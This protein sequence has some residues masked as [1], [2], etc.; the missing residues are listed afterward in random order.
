MPFVDIGT[1]SPKISEKTEGLTANFV[2]D[3][4]EIKLQIDNG[5]GKVVFTKKGFPAK[6]FTSFANM[7]ASDDFAN[8][9]KWAKSQAELLGR[10]AAA[11]R[12]LLPFNARN[13]K[14]A[15]FEGV[16]QVNALFN[17]QPRP[18]DAAEVILIDGPAGIGKTKL[19]EQ[20]ALLR[21]E[22]YA[23]SPTSLILHVR[24]RGRVLS[25]LQDLMA[26][27]LQ[28]LRSNTTYDQIPILLKHGLIVVAIDGFDELGDPNG[29]ELAWSQV[30]DLISAARG[31]GVVL[32]SGRDT[33]LGRDRLFRDVQSLRQDRDVV[34][35]LT[36]EASTPDQAREWLKS[37]GWTDVHFKIPAV[38]S[39]L[40]DGSF[41]LR[42]VFLN[43]MAANLEPKRLREESDS[44][45]TPLLVK[46]ML[47]REAKLFGDAVEKIVSRDSLEDFLL[48]YLIEVAREMADGQSESLDETTLS[49]IVEIALGDG[50]PE[51]VV[52]LIRNRASVVAALKPDLRAGYKG[53]VHSHIQNYFLSLA[54]LE[55]VGKGEVPK[56]LKRNVLG[57]EMVAVF[58]DVAAKAAGT[59][60]SKAFL[61]HGLTMASLYGGVDRASRNVGALLMSTLALLSDGEVL[62]DSDIDETVVRGTA[63]KVTLSKVSI[64]QLDC[65]AAD[66]GSVLFD[67]CKIANL[68]AN[69]G[70][71]LSPSFPIPRL[72]AL[73]GGADLVESDQIDEWLTRHGRN[74]TA[75]VVNGL[76]SPALSEHPLFKLLGSA[77]RVRQYWLRL[78]DDVQA[79]KI[80]RSK[81]W[82][83]LAAELRGCNLLR[84]EVRQAAGAKSKFTHIR[85]R[86]KI[87]AEDPSDPDVVK[88]F[89]NLN[90]RVTALAG[91]GQLRVS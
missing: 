58:G 63:S 34:I 80:L 46:H 8:L 17:S 37:R 75:T 42:P 89:E 88:L 49:W 12:R 24:S 62:R 77:C 52:R 7:L 45:L 65:R 16:E 54:T 72:I 66:L 30:N 57:S 4:R 74:A 21:A 5:T 29:Y 25:N 36:V 3:G 82:D 69:D 27:S 33:F 61:T 43:L 56:F 53:F 84:E 35:S 79:E 10:A 6:G 22:A 76:A 28:T 9:K 48:R 15:R 60:Q 20:L 11:E 55:A 44:F 18:A 70:T 23:A 73:E 50:Y 40:D 51:E 83:E 67:D 87:L 86:E 31:R 41:A 39:L 14:N 1:P 59:P 47:E 19:V 71:R 64:H 32:L 90:A 13:H 38:A 91:G 68:I 26:F 2:R 78:G 85:M 81:Y